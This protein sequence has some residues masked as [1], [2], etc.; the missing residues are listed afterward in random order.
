VETVH[1]LNE[2]L[3]V[4]S[5]EDIVGVFPATRTESVFMDWTTPYTTM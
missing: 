2:V 3:V 1:I 4:P 5:E